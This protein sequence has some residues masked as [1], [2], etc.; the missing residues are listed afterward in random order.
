MQTNTSLSRTLIVAVLGVAAGLG[1]FAAHRWLQTPPPPPEYRSAAVYAEPRALPAVE[2][3]TGDGRHGP[4][5]QLLAGQWR[6]VFFGFTH[7]PEVCPGAM[8]TLDH[9]ARELAQTPATASGEA[10]SAPAAAVPMPVMTLI[11]IDPRRD[12][13]EVVSN[14]VRGF[15]PAFEGYSGSEAAIDELAAAVGVAVM[16]GAPDESGNY[17]VDH[18]SAVFVFDPQGRVRG[19]LT[20]PL[21]ATNIAHD[22]RLIAGAQP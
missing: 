14:Y 11:S 8:K 17:M 3:A 1:V 19:L 22:Y 9:V 18:T 12:T 10:P 21:T 2:L 7:C 15:N 6:L 20:A 13:P 4:A 16:R 5:N